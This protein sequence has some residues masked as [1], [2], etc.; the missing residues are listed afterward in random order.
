MLEAEFTP[1]DR[2]GNCYCF[3][4]CG[5]GEALASI[6]QGLLGFGYEAGA[7]HR[8]CS[9][10]YVSNCRSVRYEL[11]E[12]KIHAWLSGTSAEPGLSPAS[13]DLSCKPNA[14]PWA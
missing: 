13:E 5:S 9:F 11:L 3:A 1:Q 8:A 2:A 12:R 7:L 6:E 14:C 10:G 4:R